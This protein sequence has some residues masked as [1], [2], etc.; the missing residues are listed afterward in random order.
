MRNLMRSDTAHL[1][2]GPTPAPI[3]FSPTLPLQGVSRL[4]ASAF[5][6]KDPKQAP[7][8][9]L[10]GELNEI[11]RSICGARMRAQPLGGPD[12]CHNPHVRPT[13]FAWPD[14]VRLDS[15]GLYHPAYDSERRY[16]AHCHPK[17][18]DWVGQPTDPAVVLRSVRCPEGNRFWPT[19]VTRPWQGPLPEIWG[20]PGRV[21]RWY[22]WW[23]L[24][25]VQ[26][27]TCAACPGPPQVIDHH[28]TN[29]LVRGLLCYEC[30]LAEALCAEK[31]ALHQHPRLCWYERY[32]HSPP[33]A[34]FGWYWPDPKRQGGVQW[35]LP[36]PPDWAADAKPPPTKCRPR[37]TTWLLGQDIQLGHAPGVVGR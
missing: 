13:P 26:N 17:Y 5:P 7:P 14:Q 9:R 23:R 27:G 12:W 35:F 24:W 2:S 34:Q 22:I 3:S 8:L 29:G 28:H 6:A 36:Q 25:G 15:Q 10:A 21:P 1:G 20:Q 4:L 19:S 16:C 30:N 33:A 32:W 37:C 18:A 11:L 31:L